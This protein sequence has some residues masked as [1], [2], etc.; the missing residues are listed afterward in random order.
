[1]PT[2]TGQPQFLD[3]HTHIGLVGYAF[4]QLTGDSRAGATLGDFKSRVFGIGPQI[5]YI[6]EPTTPPTG[7]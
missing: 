1:M 4:R 5:G 7:M 6:F 3:E 2:S